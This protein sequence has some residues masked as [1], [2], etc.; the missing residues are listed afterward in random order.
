[1]VEVG[2][3]ESL[4]LAVCRVYAHR[5]WVERPY[6]AGTLRGVNFKSGKKLAAT[7]KAIHKGTPVIETKIYRA[8]NDDGK[9][10]PY[11]TDFE[12]SFKSDLIYSEKDIKNDIANN[13]EPTTR[14]VATQIKN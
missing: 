9:F 10:A 6:E 4:H 3:K 1:M 5:Y 11:F 12:T 2:V 14:L 13:N 7:V 8:Q